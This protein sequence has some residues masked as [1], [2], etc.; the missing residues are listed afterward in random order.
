MQVHRRGA[1]NAEKAAEKLKCALASALIILIRNQRS[2][3]SLYD[4]LCALC[5]SAVNNPPY[6]ARTMNV[7]SVAAAAAA[8]MA[9]VSKTCPPCSASV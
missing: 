9:A 5:V 2:L 1:E 6:R 7:P 8:G 4:L 3:A